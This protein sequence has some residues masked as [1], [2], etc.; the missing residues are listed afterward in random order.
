[1][2]SPKAALWIF[3]LGCLLSSARLIL[4]RSDAVYNANDVTGRSDQRFAAL[5]NLLP[6]RGIVGYI[7]QSGNSTIGYYYLT[8]YA[9]APVIVDHSLNHP[10]VVGNFPSSRPAGLPDNLQLVRDFGD[11]V[12]L[13][14]NKDAN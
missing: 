7:G 8:Q 2:L 1:M 9:L 4:D 11:G 13:F 5:R 14:V 3:V 12:F 6:K 10:F